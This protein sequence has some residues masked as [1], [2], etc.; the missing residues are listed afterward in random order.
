MTE[1]ALMDLGYK[2][3]A[4]AY[5]IYRQLREDERIIAIPENLEKCVVLVT[6]IAIK[7][8]NEKIYVLENDELKV[9]YELTDAD[10][11]DVGSQKCYRINNLEFTVNGELTSCEFEEVSSSKF[12][13][14][15]KEMKELRRK[16]E[17]EAASKR[18]HDK[19]MSE[20]NDMTPQFIEYLT[21]ELLSNVK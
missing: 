2:A 19:I 21:K 11:N 13:K 7:N 16:Q 6:E 14:V 15:L 17:E 10:F 9:R 20:F 18:E 12:I 4:K 1:F 3:T 5:I 8:F